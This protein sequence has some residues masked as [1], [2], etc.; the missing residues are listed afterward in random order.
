MLPGTFLLGLQHVG[1][2]EDFLDLQLK[3]H[4]LNIYVCRPSIFRCPSMVG[5]TFYRQIATYCA[6]RFHCSTIAFVIGLD[7]GSLLLALA[8]DGSGFSIQDEFYIPT[9]FKSALRHFNGGMTIF[10]RD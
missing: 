6:Q 9:D 8:I 3:I 1:T 4:F 5:C 10:V 7:L 2:S